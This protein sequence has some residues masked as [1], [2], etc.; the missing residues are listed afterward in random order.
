M[1]WASFCGS[2]VDGAL[3][4]LVSISLSPLPLPSLVLC[5]ALENMPTGRPLVYYLYSPNICLKL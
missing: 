1:P 2:C 3:G 4:P 5:L